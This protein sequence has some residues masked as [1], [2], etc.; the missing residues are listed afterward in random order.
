MPNGAVAPGKVLPS[1]ADP[2]KGSTDD[3]GSANPLG[4]AAEATVAVVPDVSRSAVI[5][6]AAD[7]RITGSVEGSGH[8]EA[9]S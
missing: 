5:T 3:A 9:N 2:I 1:P 7:R 8:R 4:D 6:T